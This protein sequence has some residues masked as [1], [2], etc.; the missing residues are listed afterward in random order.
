MAK[1]LYEN[2][3]MHVIALRAQD[4]VRTSSDPYGMYNTLGLEEMVDEG[5]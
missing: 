3:T 5:W 4:I 1:K 2:P